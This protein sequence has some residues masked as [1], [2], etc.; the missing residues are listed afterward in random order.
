M[1][2][3]YYSGM[4]GNAKDDMGAVMSDE[5][6]KGSVGSRF[7]TLLLHSNSDGIWTPQESQKLLLE[8]DEITNSFIPE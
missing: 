3:F 8:L 2:S 1:V 4:K 5:T 7:P 6:P